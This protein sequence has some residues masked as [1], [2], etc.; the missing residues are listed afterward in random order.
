MLLA[1]VSGKGGGMYEDK[2]ATLERIKK[3]ITDVLPEN[4]R[5][6]LVLEND[7]VITYVFLRR[8]S[9]LQALVDLL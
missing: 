3:T 9:H 7:E 1:D 8:T 4:V 6:R 5:N 2:T